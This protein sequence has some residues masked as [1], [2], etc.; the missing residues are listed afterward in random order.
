MQINVNVKHLATD[1]FNSCQL[2]IDSV[3][4][5]L[6]KSYPATFATEQFKL[7]VQIDRL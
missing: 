1:L 7:E 6:L 5:E 4:L 2:L 3:T